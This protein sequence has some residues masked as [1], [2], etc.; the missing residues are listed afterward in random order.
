MFFKFWS[1]ILGYLSIRVEGVGLEKFVNMVIS[2]GIYL[3]D[4][5]LQGD[6]RMILNVRVH[7]FKA[8]RHIAKKL[9]CRITIEQKRG[10]PFIL[11]YFK[12]RK[13]L[14]AG[15]F[16]FL[17]ALY[18][19]SSFIWFVDVQGADKISNKTILL[20]LRDAGLDKGTPK[21][22]INTK[23]MEKK[24]GK[25][26]PQLAWIGIKIKGTK[27]LVE[28]VEKKMSGE[29][30]SDQNPAHIIATK[31]GVIKEILVMRGEAAVKEGQLVK[32][33]QILISGILLPPESEIQEVK[34]EGEEIEELEE[35]LPKPKYV[36]AKGIVKGRVWYQTIAEAKILQIEQERTGNSVDNLRIKIQ[37]K[38]IILKGPK[39][40]NFKNYEKVEKVN[41][42]LQWRNLSI[43]V[44]VIS[45]TYF[46]T[47]EIKHNLGYNGAKELAIG[48][49]ED[50]IR[51]KLSPEAEI[52]NKEIEEIK[53]TDKNKVKYKVTIEAI[54]SIGKLRYIKEK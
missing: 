14:V 22:E 25:S 3:W 53:T 5:S 46:E 36:R 7:S 47:K 50:R 18:V 9:G 42:L 40:I 28:V 21:W 6:D 12:Q 52:V 26:I 43:P 29:N 54:E 23:E 48:A 15:A 4:I 17:I 38:E 10:L 2:R 11:A 49:A 30:P 16:T 27:A 1:Y 41:K 13:M 33:G 34:P 39:K 44:E 51:N 45:T 32:K 24:V 20:A 31:K 8:L 37:G 35:D 19:L